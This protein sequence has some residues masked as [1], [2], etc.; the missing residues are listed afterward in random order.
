[1]GMFNLFNTED[2]IMC[3]LCFEMKTHSELFR[4]SGGFEH[5]I[6][7]PCAREDGFTG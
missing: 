1:M 2:S 7:K 6:C 4:D 5:D 3:I